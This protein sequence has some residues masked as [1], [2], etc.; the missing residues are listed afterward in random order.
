MSR[1]VDVVENITK[2]L[3][4]ENL[5]DDFSAKVVAHAINS[6]RKSLG[7]YTLDD[8]EID[9]REL[10]KVVDDFRMKKLKHHGIGII[11]LEYAIAK[12]KPIKIKA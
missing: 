8:I 9:K 5:L 4:S 6:H 11:D 10:I 2:Q 3:V 1:E 12:A 7:L